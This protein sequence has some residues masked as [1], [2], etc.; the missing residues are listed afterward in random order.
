MSLFINLY[1]SLILPNLIAKIPDLSKITSLDF[2]INYSISS[3]YPSSTL[4]RRLLDKLP[5]LN[6]LEISYTYLLCLLKSPLIVKLLSKKID[7]LSIVFDTDTP[8]L[9]DI[10]RILNIF[11]NKL[12]SLTFHI[13]IDFQAKKFFFI[14]LPIFG[15]ICK[16][17]FS[18]RL[19][20]RSRPGQSPAIFDEEF[21]LKVKNC[22]AAQVQKNQTKSNSMEYRIKNNEILIA[23]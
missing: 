17:L 23:F 19:K 18:F 21:K 7:S 22:L 13:R 14:F 16:K 1:F 9:P 10:I 4:A 15:G 5:K 12:R 6:R 11:A 8:M 2:T 3:I 20:L